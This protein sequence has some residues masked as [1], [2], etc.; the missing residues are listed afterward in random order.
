MTSDQEEIK[1]AF[2]IP[3]G[4]LGDGK[5]LT[6]EHI[7]MAREEME[8]FETDTVWYLPGNPD[9]VWHWR[10][11]VPP[12]HSQFDEALY[13]DGFAFM[14]DFELPS[15][16]LPDVVQDAPKNC[17]FCKGEID[18]VF[19][20]STARPW[21]KACPTCFDSRVNDKHAKEAEV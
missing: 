14:P 20:T 15:P 6:A 21:V 1:R 2:D 16:T 19:H 5:Y 11:F 3:P 7:R 4:S 10:D 8:A 13:A 9:L 17:Y 12:D 18:N